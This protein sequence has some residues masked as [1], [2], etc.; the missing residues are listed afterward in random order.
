[1]ALVHSVVIG[2]TRGIG[3]AV[4]RALAGPGRRVSVIGRRPA[5]A[6]DRRPGVRYWLSSITDT[7]E[8]DRT[9]R[10][11]I[12]LQGP[13]DNLVLLQRYRGDGDAWAGELAVSL[14]ATKQVIERL[15]GRFAR[16]GAI[17]VM[18]SVAARYIAEEQPVGY[19]VAKAGLAQMVRYY[20]RV[21]GPRR[22]RVNSISCGTVVKEE[23]RAYYRR[24]PRLPALYRRVTPLRRMA[25]AEDIAGV[26]SFLCGPG[27][28]FMTGQDI[29]LDG[30]LS[31]LWH[32]ALA[33][34]A[35][36]GPQ[37]AEAR[38]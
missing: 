16:G 4:V 19:H 24:S 18:S 26:V 32:E 5:P 30:G 25:T 37:L 23:S 9:L 34:Q 27:A 15:A 10:E 14:T 20:A 36:S 3:R 2:G 12:R 7:A 22:I 21:L 38:R 11:L 13:V 6:S 35:A 8:L 17:V 29:L 1:M 33:R 31:L 28:A